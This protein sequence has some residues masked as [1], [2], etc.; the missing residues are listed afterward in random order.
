MSAPLMTLPRKERYNAES[1]SA[2]MYY[3]LKT[4]PAAYSFSDLRRDKTT[5]WDGVKNPVAV[6]NL[7][8]MK[9]GDEIIVYHTGGEKRAVG[10]ATVVSVDASDPKFPAVLIEAGRELRKPVPLA[11]MKAA[12]AF[13]DSP[14]LR[15]GRLSVVPLTASQY[16]LI[17][18]T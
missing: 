8:G 13:R 11:E 15:Q 7:R 3:L 12:P 6:K 14:I 17:A 4:E 9:T 5:V 2:R 1:R 18:G 10:T 16:R